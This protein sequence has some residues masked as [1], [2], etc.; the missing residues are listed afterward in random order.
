[1]SA[2]RSV[3]RSG[4]AAGGIILGIGPDTR[5]DAWRRGR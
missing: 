4:A 1:M 2:V 5:D 3:G